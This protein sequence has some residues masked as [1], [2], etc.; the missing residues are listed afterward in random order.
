MQNNTFADVYFC[1][2]TAQGPS[3]CCDPG[4]FSFCCSDQNNVFVDG[5]IAGNYWWHPPSSSSTSN[6]TTSSTKSASQTDAS[7]TPT[8]SSA[9]SKPSNTGVAIGAGVGVGVGVPLLGILAF[10]VWRER[11]NTSKL[12]QQWQAEMERRNAAQ[13]GLDSKPH[14]GAGSNSGWYELGS[15]QPREL[16]GPPPRELDA[17]RQ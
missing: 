1:G 7:H 12:R 10:L 8:S 13:S 4:D 2:F 3:W 15:P 5:N 11:R 6:A 16:G 14:Q 17:Q 9:S